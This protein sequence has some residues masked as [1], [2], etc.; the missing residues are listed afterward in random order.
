MRATLTK[1][2]TCNCGT[3]FNCG[4]S[5]TGGCWCMNLPNM[6]PGFDLAGECV[7]PECLTLGQ[8]K[9]ITRQRKAHKALRAGQ[10]IR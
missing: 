2:R 10:R 8:A 4:G 9:A 6:R 7:C 3:E 5:A 1:K